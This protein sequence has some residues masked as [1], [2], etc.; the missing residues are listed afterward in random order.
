MNCENYK[1]KIISYIDNDL[2]EDDKRLFEEELKNNSELNTEYIEMKNLLKTLKDLPEVKTSRNFMVTLN[3]K[4]DRYEAKKNYKWY[5]AVFDSVVSN[6]RPLQG[7]IAALAVILVIF[8]GY[9]VLDSD[10]SQ[11]LMLSNSNLSDDSEINLTD[12]EI[13]SLIDSNTDKDSTIE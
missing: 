4:I 8:I 12:S 13:D 3:S 6:I 7:G 1:D 10:N 11:P 9:N 5:N 2:N